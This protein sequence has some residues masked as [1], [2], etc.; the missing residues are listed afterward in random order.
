MERMPIYQ[1]WIFN[2]YSHAGPLFYA[3]LIHLSMSYPP[4][5]G[6]LH[7]RYSPVRRSPAMV[8]KPT[9]PLPLDLH[10][11]S[12]SLAF[13]LSQDQ[14][15]RCCKL[16]MS[17]A[18][19]SVTIRFIKYWRYLF[20]KYLYYLLIYVIFSKN[21]VAIVIFDCGCKG[22]NFYFNLPNFFGSFFISFFSFRNFAWISPTSPMSDRI[23][24]LQLF[25][26]LTTASL[27]I[28]GAKVERI[29]ES[30]KYFWRKF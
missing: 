9:T 28:A 3:V 8:G 2:K 29:F 12:L 6:K 26:M 19:D 23:T 7:T 13:I 27:S 5:I 22:K 17:Y 14:T 20:S 4:L 11:L 18:Q 15:L 10:V 21:L 25:I 1:R 24:F 16:F 30:A